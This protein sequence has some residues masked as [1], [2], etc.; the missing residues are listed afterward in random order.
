MRYGIIGFLL[1]LTSAVLAEEPAPNAAQKAFADQVKATQKLLRE[2]KAFEVKAES[3]WKLTGGK[4][5]VTGQQSVLVTSNA[6]NKLAIIL[7]D[8]QDKEGGLKILA[9]GQTITRLMPGLRIYSQEKYTGSPLDELQADGVTIPA[10]RNAGVDFLARPD[11]LAV[12]NTQTLAVEDLGFAEANGE[13]THGYRL[14]LVAGPVV[15]V[16]FSTG[17]RPVPIEVKS[18]LVLAVTKEKTY[19]RTLAVKLNWDWAAKER[20]DWTLPI[21]ADMKKVDD[22]QEAILAPDLAEV[23]GTPVPDVSFQDADGKP[24]KLRDDTGKSIVVV[25]SWATWAAPEGKNLPALNEFVKAFSEKGVKF[26]AVNV[27]DTPAAAKKYASDAKFT[28]VLTLDPKGSSLASLRVATVPGVVIVGK[29]GTLQA[30]YRG[31][32]DTAA[33]VQADLE[34]LLRGEQLVPKKQ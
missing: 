6:P 1:L 4:A 30:V 22:L 3:Q 7:V 20:T 10:L 34:K 18:T 25:Y 33:K 13:K 12:L 28:G 17:E 5:D 19:T 11:M 9:D 24:W 29:D 23:L 15:E 16:R 26:V 31:Q 27:G 14:T 8:P 21:P 32:A 2:A